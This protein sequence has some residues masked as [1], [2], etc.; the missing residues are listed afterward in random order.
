MNTPVGKTFQKGPYFI[1]NFP[2]HEQQRGSY[3][4]FLRSLATQTMHSHALESIYGSVR[5]C[6]ASFSFF[7]H[8]KDGKERIEWK[9]E[10]YDPGASHQ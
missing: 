5:D 10:D 6:C 8:D 4:L 7:F 3:S 9:R 1:E 2:K